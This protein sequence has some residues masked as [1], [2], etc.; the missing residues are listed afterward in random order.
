[1]MLSTLPAFRPSISIP[2]DLRR[3]V[4]HGFFDALVWIAAIAVTLFRLARATAAVFFT[5]SLRPATPEIKSAFCSVSDFLD[6]EYSGPVPPG[7]FVPVFT[8]AARP[9]SRGFASR[10]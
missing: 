7:D 5:D 4:L 10:P 8:Q 3:T 6:A 2:P 9:R 1:M